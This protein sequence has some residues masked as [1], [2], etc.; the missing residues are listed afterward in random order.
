MLR[1]GITAHLE[2]SNAWWVLANGRAGAL[3]ETVGEATGA[4]WELY[5]VML[6]E[7]K[8]ACRQVFNTLEKVFA[9]Q[10]W[11]PFFDL[12]TTVWA[13]AKRRG[14]CAPAPR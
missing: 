11:G 10:G 13:R 14:S 9:Q 6:Q 1:E 5:D 4:D 7:D 12:R 8:E 3:E 2:S